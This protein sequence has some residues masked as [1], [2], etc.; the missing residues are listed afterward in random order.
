MFNKFCIKVFQAI[1]LTV[2]ASSLVTIAVGALTVFSSSGLLCLEKAGVKTIPEKR[3]QQTLQL[4]MGSTLLGGV[5][6]VSASFAA[7][8]E[9]HF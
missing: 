2:G 8:C 1:N 9:D 3:I 5:G 4:G 6:F 7:A